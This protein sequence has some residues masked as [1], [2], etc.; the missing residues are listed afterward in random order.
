MTIK[1]KKARLQSPPKHTRSIRV[2]V[3]LQWKRGAKKTTAEATLL[4][5]SGATGPVLNSSWVKETQMPC[6]RRKVA[7]PISDASGNHIPGSGLHYTKEVKMRIG[8]HVNN[9]M[10]ELAE[11]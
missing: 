6:V 8:D 11:I 5:D 9:M 3:R 4:L 7:L 10:F 2:K 1:I